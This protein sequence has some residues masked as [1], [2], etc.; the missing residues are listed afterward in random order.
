M[1]HGL[2]AGRHSAAASTVRAAAAH[3]I[4]TLGS[5]DIPGPQHVLFGFSRIENDLHR[6]TLHNF[7]IIAGGVFRRQQAEQRAAGPGNAFH[8]AFIF[9]AVGVDRNGDALSRPHFAQLVLFEIGRDPDVVKV[10]DLHQLLPDGNVLPDFHGAI[11]DDSIH[12]RDNLCVLQIQL[13]LIQF[14]FFLL[15]L[16]L[17]RLRLRARNLRSCC[18]AVFA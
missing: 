9:F 5:T 2:T 14:G 1:I 4:Q 12:R 13:R 7:H 16:R 3:R 10:D 17:R 6:N 11:A 18:G 15:S 8:L